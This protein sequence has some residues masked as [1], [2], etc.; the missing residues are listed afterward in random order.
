MRE[1]YVASF[2]Y[3]KANL[4]RAEVVRETQKS[5]M[6]APN[7]KRILGWQYL[8]DRLSKEKHHCFDTLDEGLAYLE[9]AQREHILACRE[10]LDDAISEHHKLVELR[11]SCNGGLSEWIKGGD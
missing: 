6:I 9:N 4:D 5:F 7:F 2:S 8:P 10:K 11:C 3:G 1:I